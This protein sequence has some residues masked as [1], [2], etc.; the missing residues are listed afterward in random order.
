MV[1][2]IKRAQQLVKLR[3]AATNLSHPFA[4]TLDADLY[5]IK[6]HFRAL[7]RL[8]TKKP[9]TN[10]KHIVYFNLDCGAFVGAQSDTKKKEKRLVTVSMA[11]NQEVEKGENCTCLCILR[12]MQLNERKESKDFYF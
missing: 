11:I 9:N 3:K 1:R 5:L 6:F 12:S 7:A 8:S 2:T 4:L 10:T